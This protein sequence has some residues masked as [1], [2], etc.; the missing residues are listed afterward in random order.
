VP[1]EVAAK[2][3]PLAVAARSH[4]RQEL[5][6]RRRDVMAVLAA[7]AILSLFGALLTGSAFVIF[8]Q[9]MADMALAA[10]IYLLARATGALARAGQ[11]S[12]GA[13]AGGLPVV[14]PA[15]DFGKSGYLRARALR[16]GGWQEASYGDFGSY[17]SLAVTRG[18]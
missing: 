3:H 10:Y 1:H 12:L 6:R 16:G 9:V 18:H 13:R 17:A 11:V 8:L 5:R 4:S 2:P 14:M 7:T 15:A